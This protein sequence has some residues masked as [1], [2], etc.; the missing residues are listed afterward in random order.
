MSQTAVVHARIDAATKN[1]TE[2]ILDA[3]GMTPT[4]AIRLFYRQIALRREFPVELHVP[5]K[6]TAA[7]L[8]QS[9]KDKRVEH[10]D[11]LEELYASWEG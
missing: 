3:L 5:N 8:D 1:A 2:K 11:S 4:E 7:T 6:L 9:D 10:F